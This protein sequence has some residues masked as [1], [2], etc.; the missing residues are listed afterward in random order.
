M[1][2]KKWLAVGALVL[3]IT[4]VGLCSCQAATTS[5]AGTN[6][7]Q[8]QGIWVNGQGKVSV[9]PDVASLRLGIEAEEATVAEAQEQAAE[10]MDKIMIALTEKG[11]AESDIKTQYFNIY[12]VT[13]WDRDTEEE[14]VTGYRVTNMVTAKVR[15]IDT[16]GAVIDAV[17]VAGEDLTRVDSISFSVDDPSEY[18]AEARAEAMAEAKE[19]AEQLAELADV[20]LGKPIYISEG[21]IPTPIYDRYAGIAFEEAM[22]ASSAIETPISPGE[23]EISLSVQVVFAILN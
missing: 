13:K 14:I 22:G 7:S 8:Q 5:T 23:I 12:R 21:G 9:T 16:I 4:L 6:S 20:T 15:D 19:K 17:A 3:T 11:V 18:Y 2:K 10:A 1:N